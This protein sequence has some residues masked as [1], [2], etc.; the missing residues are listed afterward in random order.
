M[1]D[2]NNEPL[3]EDGNSDSAMPWLAV[4]AKV[5]ALNLAMKNLNELT[6][7]KP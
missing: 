2:D 5:Q 1:L 3:T 6:H 4:V 7:F